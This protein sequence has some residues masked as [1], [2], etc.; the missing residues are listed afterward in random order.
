MPLVELQESVYLNLMKYRPQSH[1][2]VSN[3]NSRQRQAFKDCYLQTLQNKPPVL[4]GLR[5]HKTEGKEKAMLG[6]YH[7]EYVYQRY[8]Q[9]VSIKRPVHLDHLIWKEPTS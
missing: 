7:S 2:L 5:G 1:T 9:L 4:C 3:Y 8:S 6:I